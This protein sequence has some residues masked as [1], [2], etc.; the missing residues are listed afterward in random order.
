MRRGPGQASGQYGGPGRYPHTALFVVKTSST[1]KTYA[2]H[3][4]REIQDLNCNIQHSELTSVNGW[5]YARRAHHFK[6]K[7]RVNLNQCH[8]GYRSHFVVCTMTGVRKI[9]ISMYVA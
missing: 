5:G 3:N 7:E 1:V 8:S 2:R 4:A 6:T 9:G